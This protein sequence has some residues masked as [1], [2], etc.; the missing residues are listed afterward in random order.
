M[1]QLKLT[2]QWDN[3]LVIILPDHGIGYPAG[4]S[5][6]DPRRSHIPMIWTGGAV[7]KAQHVDLICNQTDL[8]ATLLG[9]LGLPHDDF[10]FSRDVM[11]RTYTRPSAVHVWSEG[12]FYMDDSGVSAINLLA[13]PQSVFSETPQPSPSRRQAANALLQVAY[14]DLGER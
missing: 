13:K 9:Q 11:S 5:D 6:T 3:T 14:D 8:P 4:I 12:I 7:K 1:A 2:K 10:R